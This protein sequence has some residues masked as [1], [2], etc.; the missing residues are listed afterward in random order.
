MSGGG[1]QR[2]R[3]RATSPRGDV[4]ALLRARYG[5]WLRAAA[6]YNLVWGAGTVLFPGFAFNVL[7]LSVPAPVA[8]WQLVG[9]FVLV[10]APVYWWASQDPLRH[11]HLV[12]VG[13]AGK[14][15]GPLGFVWAAATGALPLAFGWILVTN[16]LLWWPALA[17]CLHTASRHTGGWM[18]MLRGR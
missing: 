15:L 10:Y 5:P 3:L 16:D 8:I 1:V 9:M 2:Q 18:E 4:A 14:T 7:G 11:R 17:A 12:L 6:I 13:F